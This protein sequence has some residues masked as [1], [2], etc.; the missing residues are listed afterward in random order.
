MHISVHR[1]FDPTGGATVAEDVDLCTGLD[2][3]PGS[4]ILRI[5]GADD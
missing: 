1:S 2:G 3:M 5:R 4:V